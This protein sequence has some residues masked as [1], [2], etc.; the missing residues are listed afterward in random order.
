MATQS[1]ILRLQEQLLPTR[2]LHFAKPQVFCSCLEETACELFPDGIPEQHRLFRSPFKAKRDRLNQSLYWASAVETYNERNLTLAR[3]KLV[4]IG[5]LARLLAEQNDNKYVVGLWKNN[6]ARELCWFHSGSS[7]ESFAK[8]PKSN[9]YV[10]PSWSWASIDGSV[11]Y[12]PWVDSSLAFGQMEQQCAEVDA[13]QIEY[14]S[15]DNPFGQ[16][17]SAKLRLKCTWLVKCDVWPEDYRKL[18]YS[19]PGSSKGAWLKVKYDRLGDIM[20]YET[21][22][23]Y[24]LPIV[25]SPDYAQGV[26]LLIQATGCARGEY[27]RL[28]FIEHVSARTRFWSNDSGLIYGF[29]FADR[30]WIAAESAYAMIN[31]YGGNK[32][33]FIDLV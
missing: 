18:R 23:W 25:H 10:A 15:P 26:G 8:V 19:S 21:K 3:D 30:S 14:E 27:R 16:V 17:L 2:T 11:R 1:L 33:Y 12:R 31:V 29:D 22:N 7:M 24:F 32:E 6:L 4:A 20:T 28:G 5:G 9:S 13:L